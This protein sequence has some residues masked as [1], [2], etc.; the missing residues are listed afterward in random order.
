VV[1]LEGHTILYILEDDTAFN[2]ENTLSFRFAEY[3]PGLEAVECLEDFD[4]SEGT[5][6]DGVCEVEE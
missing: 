3:Y 5:C 4:C 6:V 1:P 2:G